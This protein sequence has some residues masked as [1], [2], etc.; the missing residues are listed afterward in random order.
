M[1]FVQRAADKADVAAK[2]GQLVF[3]I[4]WQ[5]GDVG[6]HFG[7][8]K[9]VVFGMDDQQRCLDR[10]QQRQGTA[11]TVIISGVAE[12]VDACCNGIVK[13]TDPTQCIKLRQFER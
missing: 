3:N 4:V 2:L 9:G 11:T 7:G 12:T 1:G 6:D 5:A 8:H 13:V 10:R